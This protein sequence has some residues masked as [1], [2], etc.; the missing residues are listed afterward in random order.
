MGRLSG[1]TQ[2]KVFHRIGALLLNVY[3]F[4]RRSCDE[5]ATARLARLARLRDWPGA[6]PCGGAPEY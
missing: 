5:L 3:R 1:T 2:F 6:Q 4:Y